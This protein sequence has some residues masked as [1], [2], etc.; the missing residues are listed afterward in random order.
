LQ[1]TYT[2]EGR[3]LHKPDLLHPALTYVVPTGAVTQTLYF[4]GGNST[5]EL[6]T[7]VLLRDGR[8]MRYFPIGAKGS[9]HVPLRVVEDLLGDTK[10]ELHVAAPEGTTGTV[11]VDLGMVEV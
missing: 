8:P 1:G 5:D 11:V 9:T 2:F 7:L 6:V 10:L 3:G 4:R